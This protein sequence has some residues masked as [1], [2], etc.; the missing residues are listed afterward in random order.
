ME[1]K[2]RNYTHAGDK[3]QEYFF[4]NIR[5]ALEKYVEIRDAIPDFR[6]RRQL[7]PTIW[8]DTEKGYQ[9]VHDFAFQDV[10]DDSV[11]KYLAERILDTDD[12][13][14]FMSDRA[15]TD[16]EST[17]S[18]TVSGLEELTDQESGIIVYGNRDVVICNWRGVSGL[19]RVFMGGLVGL[20]EELEAEPGED[21][22]DVACFLDDEYGLQ[23]LDVIYD[24]NGDMAELVNEAV[25]GTAYRLPEL[26]ALVV[27]PD[28][29]C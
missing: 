25:S 13:L 26:D 5:E 10:T 1:I 12:L 23:N 14:G 16:A 18:R 20:G 21:V 9:R 27:A 7:W 8:V 6:N 15:E 29:W 19:P 17:V 22:K 28:G 11:G 2:V 4:N 24:V 3:D